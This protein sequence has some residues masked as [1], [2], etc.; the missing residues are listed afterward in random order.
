MTISRTFRTGAP[1]QIINYDFFDLASGRIIQKFY[2]TSV[3]DDTTTNY[4]LTDQ[5]VYA[6]RPFTK[7]AG[8]DS[9][10]FTL[11]QDIDFDI[12]FKFPKIVDG[13]V[14]ISMDI[15]SDVDGSAG[16]TETYCIFKLR[17]WD[18]STETEIASSQSRTLTN[19]AGVD[20]QIVAVEI[21][22]TN[23]LIEGG[24][25]LRCTV[26]QWGRHTSGSG[27]PNFAI[28][29]DPKNRDSSDTIFPDGQ[30]TEAWIFIPLKPTI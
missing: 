21:S 5:V 11:Q 6:D 14:I 30:V 27:T 7:V 9:T 24:N 29:H 25:T 17:H 26:E 18:G 2:F 20:N 19:T 12:L 16:N 22:V 23:S 13:T 10:T 1:G 15:G 8:D 4:L 28:T 3:Q